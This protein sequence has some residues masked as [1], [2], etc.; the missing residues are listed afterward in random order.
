MWMRYV[1]P[2]LYLN[3]EQL[4]RSASIRDKAR[5]AAG[6]AVLRSVPGVAGYYTADGECPVR[7]NG[8][9]ASRTVF[10]RCDP[11]T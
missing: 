9:A 2:F 3:H 1:Y 7:A 4:R 6:E 8:C 5:R 11:A 10:T